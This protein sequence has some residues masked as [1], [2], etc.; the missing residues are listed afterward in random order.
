MVLLQSTAFIRAAQKYISKNPTSR[1]DIEAALRLMA[2]DLSDKKLKTHK[3]KG[4]LASSWACGAG[5][6]CR[7]IF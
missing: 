3:L 6:D 2:A 1:N 5:H 4:Q 7:I